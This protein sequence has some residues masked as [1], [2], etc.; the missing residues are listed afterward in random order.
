[1]LKKG[2]SASLFCQS[3]GV[4]LIGTDLGAIAKRLCPGLQIRL[5]R[6]DSGSRLHNIPGFSR[7]SPRS[8]GFFLGARVSAW[9]CSDGM[10]II[11][12]NP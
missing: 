12:A 1:M 9:R 11:A 2:S 8:A 4:D 10:A 3:L 6:F 5:G 7:F